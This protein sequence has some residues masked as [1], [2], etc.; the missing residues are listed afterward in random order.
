MSYY[1][2]RV[3]QEARQEAM[4]LFLTDSSKHCRHK[5]DPSTSEKPSGNG[6]TLRKPAVICSRQCFETKSSYWVE[7]SP[8]CIA[9][10]EDTLPL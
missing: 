4:I 3:A 2:Q 1:V 10:Q 7:M 8:D 6:S 9:L 5:A